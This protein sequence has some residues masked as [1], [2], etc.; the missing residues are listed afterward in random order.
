MWTPYWNQVISSLQPVDEEAN[1][2]DEP[3]AETDKQEPT[4]KEGEPAEES[5]QPAD[6]AEQADESNEARVPKRFY[7]V[8]PGGFDGELRETLVENG[9][10]DERSWKRR[11]SLSSR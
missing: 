4:D 6:N 2:G 7:V 11:F 5:E 10:I 3:A 1:E 8:V 9:V